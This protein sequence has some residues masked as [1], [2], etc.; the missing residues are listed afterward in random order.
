MALN[1]V[2]DLTAGTSG[3]ILQVNSLLLPF[4]MFAYRSLEGPRGPTIRYWWVFG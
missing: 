4:P 3:G 1:T 2:K